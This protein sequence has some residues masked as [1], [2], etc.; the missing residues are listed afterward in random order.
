MILDI[1]LRLIKIEKRGSSKSSNHSLINLIY[2]VNFSASEIYNYISNNFRTYKLKF[3]SMLISWV[4]FIY[5]KKKVQTKK[6]LQ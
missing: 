6:Y 4:N 1:Y 3:L 2:I 5:Y